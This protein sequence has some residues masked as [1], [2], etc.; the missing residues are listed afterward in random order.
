MKEAYEA[1][2]AKINE[3]G[4]TFTLVGKPHIVGKKEDANLKNRI[5]GYDDNS[6][7]EYDMD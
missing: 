1:V 4:G 2:K 7:E 6:E 5:K 3:L